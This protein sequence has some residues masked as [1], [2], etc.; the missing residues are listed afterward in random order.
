MKRILKLKNWQVFG[1]LLIV[2]MILIIIGAILT[3]TTEMKTSIGIFP[4]LSV[5]TMMISYYGWLWNAGIELDKQTLSC[6]KFNVRTFKTLFTINLV[7][8]LIG[9]PILKIILHD[10]S[11]IIVNMILPMLLTSFL[12]CIYFISKSLNIAE[13]QNNLKNNSILL[14]FFQIWILPIGIWNIQPRIKQ[15]LKEK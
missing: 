6:R 9:I 5:L 12:F 4:L 10:K 13:K 3:K 15:I 2:P 11:Q 1:F 7:L 14:D 8:F